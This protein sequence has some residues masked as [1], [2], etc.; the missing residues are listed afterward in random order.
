M[1]LV[2]NKPYLYEGIQLTYTGLWIVSG[3]PDSGVFKFP[4]GN[5]RT[6]SW[7]QNGDLFW[8]D[9]D[10][11]FTVTPTETSIIG[12]YCATC[13]H[14]YFSRALHDFACCPCWIDSKH[15][16]GGYI[17]GGRSYVKCGGSGILVRLHLEQT[18]YQLEHDWRTGI[19][20][21]GLLKGRHGVDLL[22][23][24]TPLPKDLR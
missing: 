8:D 10:E 15:T 24:L 18:I 22:S 7:D 5:T 4:N 13:D 16:T 1:K 2:V 17:D 11:Y 6:F 19:N 9:T 3:Y 12:K 23:E 21:Y 20:K 14:T